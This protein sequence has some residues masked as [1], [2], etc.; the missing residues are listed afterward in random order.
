MFFPAFG[1]N[2]MDS[3]V[4]PVKAVLHERAKHAVLVVDAV[5]ERANMTSLTEG[6]LGRLR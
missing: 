1:V 6:S 2:E 3:L 5:E 4:P